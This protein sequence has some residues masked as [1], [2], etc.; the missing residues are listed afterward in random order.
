MV[1]PSS[2]GLFREFHSDDSE[3]AADRRP[4]S[5]GIYNMFPGLDAGDIGATGLISDSDSP[6][7][8]F[9]I[10]DKSSKDDDFSGGDLRESCCSG[11]DAEEGCSLG[12]DTDPVG[13]G[14]CTLM[15]G[16]N[17]GDSISLVP[18]EVYVKNVSGSRLLFALWLSS[19]SVA[20]PLYSFFFRRMA[21]GILLTCNGNWKQ[22]SV[23][24]RENI[25]LSTTT[26]PRAGITLISLIPKYTK[27]N[28][29]KSPFSYVLLQIKQS[30][31]K[32]DVL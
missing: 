30:H 7:S 8:F 31:T 20:A 4:F 14:G 9:E 5:S 28:T 6:L 12:L 27:K 26:D 11:V 16:T 1:V 2:Q 13:V 23:N 32:H 18:L 17:E 25:T 24:E 15:T 29:E 3:T 19:S 10:F 22:D 21:A